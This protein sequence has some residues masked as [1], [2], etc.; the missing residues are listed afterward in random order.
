M[1][2]SEQ[3]F[4]LNTVGHDGHKIIF[5]SNH[6]FADYNN[7]NFGEENMYIA[8]TSLLKNY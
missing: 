5:I 6:I 1:V 2:G 7:A 4:V 3:I 8:I